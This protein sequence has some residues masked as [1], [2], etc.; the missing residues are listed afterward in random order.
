VSEPLA[1]ALAEVLEPLIRRLVREE[2]RR[3]GLEWR[4]RSVR[5]AAQLLDVSEAA[6]RQ[7]AARGRLSAQKLDGHL[8][9]D[10]RDLEDTIR[11]N[12]S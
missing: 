10:V 11:R 5:Q 1:A 7:R 6:V 2:V 4:W 12:G 3:A 9:F 8:Y